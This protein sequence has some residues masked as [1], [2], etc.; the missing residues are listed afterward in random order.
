MIRVEEIKDA[1][2]ELIMIALWDEARAAVALKT[3]RNEDNN[4]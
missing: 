1:L 4:E 3:L 2:L